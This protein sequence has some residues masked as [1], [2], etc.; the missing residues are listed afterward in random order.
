MGLAQLYFSGRNKIEEAVERIRQYEPPEG[1][2]LAFS[3]GKDSIT[4]MDL[5]RSSGVSFESHYCRTGIDPPE[6]VKFIRENYPEV[7]PIPPIKT[8]WEGIVIHGLPLR[9]RRWCCQY[10]KEHAGNGRVILQGVRWAESARRRRRWNIYTEYSPYV[11]SKIH[12]IHKWFCSPIVDWSN[13]E[14]WEY[15]RLK[16]L[17]YCCLYDEGFQRLGCVL[18]PF[19]GGEALKMEIQRY[20][21]IVEAYRRAANR[22]F[23]RRGGI[24]RM[25]RWQCGDDYFNWWIQE[26]LGATLVAMPRRDW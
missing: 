12:G 26:R 8:M 21:K 18:C 14:V 25:G 4:L 2:T 10:L 1:Y 20:P 7:K 23:D 19:C 11:G 15:I 3:G 16:N 22:Y 5:A 13:E 6:L 9:H 17:K 24:D